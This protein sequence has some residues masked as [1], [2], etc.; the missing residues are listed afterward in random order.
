MTPSEQYISQNLGRRVARAPY[1]AFNA[2]LAAFLV[3]DICHVAHRFH[4]RR[5]ADFDNF[6]PAFVLPVEAGDEPYSY[7]GKIPVSPESTWRYT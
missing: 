7:T 4:E 3:S 2:A 1:L 6:W 5:V